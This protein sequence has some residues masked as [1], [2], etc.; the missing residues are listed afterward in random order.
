MQDSNTIGIYTPDEFIQAHPNQP[1]FMLQCAH[2]G[3][4]IAASRR[5]PSQLL[6]TW[7]AESRDP[8]PPHSTPGGFVALESGLALAS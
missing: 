2:P 1:H 7:L 6:H 8:S 4:G 3:S 5:L